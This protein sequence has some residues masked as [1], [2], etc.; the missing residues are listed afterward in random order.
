M[1]GGTG[2]RQ[3]SAAVGAIMA[4]WSERTTGWA[5]R[6]SGIDDGLRSI[7]DVDVKKISTGACSRDRGTLVMV[8]HDRVV[9]MD[10]PWGTVGDRAV[11]PIT[12]GTSSLPGPSRRFD[13]GSFPGNGRAQPP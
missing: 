4:N 11:V 3:V 2:Q 5:G 13:P 6:G 9:V 12:P 7:I 10:S 1:D 8:K